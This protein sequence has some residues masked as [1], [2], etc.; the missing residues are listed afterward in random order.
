MS[1]CKRTIEYVDTSGDGKDDVFRH[2]A[3]EH[4]K[5]P[6][7]CRVIFDKYRRLEY[8]KNLVER[9]DEP[10]DEVLKYEEE[11]CR[12]HTELEVFHQKYNPLPEDGGKTVGAQG[13]AAPEVKQKDGEAG[14]T[15][16]NALNAYRWFYGEGTNKKTA[17]QIAIELG[18]CGNISWKMFKN[19]A[20]KK[21]VAVL[22]NMGRD[23]TP[24]HQR[25]KNDS[26]CNKSQPLKTA[27][28]R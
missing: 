13:E 26:K 11:L 5:T 17:L 15:L 12:L 8:L 14:K 24:E 2:M 21:Q 27:P 1:K 28:R 19:A 18:L 9:I 20:A 6:H 3:K 22:I 7:E 23:N 10:T 16:A 4:G 25:S